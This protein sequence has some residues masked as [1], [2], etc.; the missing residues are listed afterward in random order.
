MVSVSVPEIAYVN[1]SWLMSVAL[2]VNVAS[3]F[4]VAI[5]LVVEVITGDW[6][7]SVISKGFESSLSFNPSPSVSGLFGFVP[8]WSSI[9]SKT[10]SPSVSVLHGLA[11]TK[12]AGIKHKIM[13]SL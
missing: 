2:I 1:V 8:F 10:P 6:L 11:L 9:K 4:S 7:G 3:L 13:R 12:N 5:K